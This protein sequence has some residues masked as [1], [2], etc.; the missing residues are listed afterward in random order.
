MEKLEL[1]KLTKALLKCAFFRYESNQR[2]KF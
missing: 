1:K 2:I